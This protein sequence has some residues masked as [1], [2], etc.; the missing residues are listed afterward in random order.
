MEIKPFFR[1]YD[2][3]IGAYIDTDNRTIYICPVPMI[4]IKI[5]WAEK[6]KKKPS[7]SG[8]LRV[9]SYREGDKVQLVENLSPARKII[10]KRGLVTKR[11]ADDVLGWINIE[12]EFD[13]VEPWIMTFDEFNINLIRR[14]K[15]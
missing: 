11:W 12:V 6:P 8:L 5:N 13:G 10:G 9:E 4:G 3:W 2:L 7:L 1:F 15:Y 14:V